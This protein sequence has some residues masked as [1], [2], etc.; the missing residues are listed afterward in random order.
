MAQL[1]TPRADAIFRFVLLVVGVGIVAA[2]LVVGG[3]AHSGYFSGVDTIAQQPVPFSHK[4]HAGELGIDCRY[5]HTTVEIAATAGMPPTWTCM[6]CHSQVWAG[7]PML[8]PVR[9]SLADDRPLQWVRVSQLPSYVYF[10]H[11]IHIAKGIGCSSCH[12]R[13]DRMQ[14]TYPVHAFSMSFCLNCHRAP[15]DFV[16]P[17]KEIFNMA[18]H[19]PADQARIGRALAQQYHIDQKVGRLTD[20][21]ICHR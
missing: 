3:I 15:Q 1:F 6:T 17:K 11:S 9:Q 16:R 10:D 5:C 7:A 14:L 20:C 12:G 19:P 18:W 13:I 4:H 8:A 21:S 2:L